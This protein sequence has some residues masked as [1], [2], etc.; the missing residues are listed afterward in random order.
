M[1]WPDNI[2]ISDQPPATYLP[3]LVKRWH[4]KEADWAAMCEAHGL[5]DGWDR[6]AYGEF[7]LARRRL[8]SDVIRRGF[9]KL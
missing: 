4:G 6:M 8:M 5:P 3:E 2:D 1:E 9:E 7:L